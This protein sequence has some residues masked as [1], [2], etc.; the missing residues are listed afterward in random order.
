ML[1]VLALVL[2]AA[3]AALA[4]ET[5]AA[6]V[7]ETQTGDSLFTVTVWLE[8]AAG[9][10][11]GRLLVNYDAD[12]LTLTKAEP[13]DAGAVTSV[14]DRS[15]GTLALA[16]VGSDLTADKTL[17]LTLTFS[18]KEGSTATV[19]AESDGIY[20]GTAAVEVAG[21]TA[22]LTVTADKSEL[23]AAIEEAEALDKKQYTEKSFAAVEDALAKAKAVVAD[24]DATQAE[25]D[26]A[27]KALNDAIAKLEKKTGGNVQTGD[28][29]MVG[30]LAVLAAAS[31]AGVGVVLTV[32]KR[33]NAA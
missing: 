8:D 17:M 9:V 14:N 15:A 13:A 5:G 27:A 19:T 20:A 6:L 31:A 16:W 22:T 10:S 24:V 25:V 2:A 12:A 18:V 32:N 21:A 33:R 1:L 7:L 11:N 4:A 26:A 29:S 3:P 28:S 30:L 23:E